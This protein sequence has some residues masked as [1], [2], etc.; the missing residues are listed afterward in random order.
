MNHTPAAA[1][2]IKNPNTTQSIRTNP[3]R[4]TTRTSRLETYNDY[5]RNA[6]TP[7]R[8]KDQDRETEVD[9]YEEQYTTRE[10]HNNNNKNY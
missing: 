3:K 8:P 10:P 2:D 5:N 4:H 6:R 7:K 1:N 9:T